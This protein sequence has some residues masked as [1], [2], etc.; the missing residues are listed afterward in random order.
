LRLL[1]RD[2]R[3]AAWL[4]ASVAAGVAS[5][6]CTIGW[7][8]VLASVVDE[9][10]LHGGSLSTVR[11]RLMA[12]VG[13][14]AL[15]ALLA[16]ATEVLADRAS[17]ILRTGV[18]AQL[19]DH[20]FAVGPAGLSRERTG[21]VAA[22]I[23]SG[24]EALHD[25]TTRF[26]PAAALGIAA[27]AVVFVAIAVLD[28]WTTLILAFTGPMLVLL[29]A[30]IGRRTR[31]LTQR[32]FDELGWLSAFYLDMVRGLGT[33]KAV[34]RSADGAE[35]I[36]DV[37]RRFGDTT[38]EVLRTAFQ[39]SLV[40]EW[41][42]TAATA[43]AAVEISF[44][45]VAGDLSFGTS[46]AVLVLVPEFFVPFR[47]LA[48]E[49]HS[50]QS[51]RAALERIEQLEALPAVAPA[52]VRR[53]GP[54]T[55][56]VDASAP[57]VD[58][59]APR[60]DVVDVVY[61]YP[62][63][64]AP[65]LDGLDLTIDAGE[66]VALVGPSGAG[67][68]TLTRLLLRFVE[69]DRGSLA[70]DGLPLGEL[71]VA[72]WRSRVA[73]VPQA[74]TIVAG[75]VADNIR[76]GD[77]SA[78][79]ARVRAAAEV[80]RA[81]EF[82]ERLPD[83]FDTELGEQGLRLSGGQRQRLAIARAALRDAPVLVLDEFTAHLDDRTEAELLEAIGALLVGRTALVVAHRRTTAAMCHRIVRLDRGRVRMPDPLEAP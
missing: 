17:G 41:A 24:V 69:P 27:P 23:G 19:V 51:G 15:R 62:G 16:W 59:A 4:A 1:V 52:A 35:T 29:L 7:L 64:P 9:V 58:R 8:V 49:Y 14:L 3:V 30:V 33:L 45:L 71:D 75:S 37:S 79:M 6:L 54:A 32:R 46:L 50:G 47:R 72:A 65:A 66:A 31:S 38:M 42:A 68:T 21:E 60:L 57:A 12:M 10:F 34:G 77:P 48:I 11:V 56:T 80:A 81:T 26:V 61:R 44:R 18:R 73:W 2:R 28:P 74:P 55:P 43:L 20:L 70:V 76:L 82:V 67:K 25:Y 63:A 5:V 13:L 22:T 78:S 39:T 53:S 36:E 40:M 83:G